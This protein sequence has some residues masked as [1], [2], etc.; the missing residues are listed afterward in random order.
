MPFRMKRKVCS[1]FPCC[2]DSTYAATGALWALAHIAPR[3][4]PPAGPPVS[5]RSQEQRGG[6]RQQR[7]KIL[8]SA[9]LLFQSHVNSG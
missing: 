1:L 2:A 5:V 8:G 6:G 3:G 9:L 7:R 4:G